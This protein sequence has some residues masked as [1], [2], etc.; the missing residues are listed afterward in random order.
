MPQ[1]RLVRGAALGGGGVAARY[2]LA[3]GPATRR[4]PGRLV[5]FGGL[6]V[7][8]PKTSSVSGDGCVFVDQ[9]TQPVLAKDTDGGRR[10]R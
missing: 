5:S 1:P 2:R 7:C 4:R 6:S 8:V 10:R 9:A 3:G